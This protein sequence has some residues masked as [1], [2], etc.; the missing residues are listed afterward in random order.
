M[1]DWWVLS[2]EM[3]TFACVL[4]DG[5]FGHNGWLMGFFLRNGDLCLCFDW[6]RLLPVFWWMT[7]CQNGWLMGFIPRNGN[8]CQ[9]SN[10]WASSPTNVYFTIRDFIMGCYLFSGLISGLLH[11]QWV[12]CPFSGL[13]S[14]TGPFSG[15]ISEFCPLPWLD[16]WA[17]T[18]FSG[19]TSEF[20]P[21]RGLTSEFCHF[22]GS[23]IG[24]YPISG[25]INELHLHQWFV[26]RAL[27]R[28]IFWLISSNVTPIKDCREFVL[29]CWTT[30]SLTCPI[31][32]QQSYLHTVIWVSCI[33]MHS[34]IHAYVARI[35][36]IHVCIFTLCLMSS[37]PHEKVVANVS[38]LKMLPN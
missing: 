14:E 33:F 21:F 38:D 29:R 32:S 34:F 30:F 15:L 25:L 7:F 31:L 13:I 24:I 19:L 8:L 37:I 28:S 2:R 17:F 18:P 12:I 5:D 3:A 26:W 11:I 27:S 6:W 22:S 36:F 23:I 20:R 10:G 16:Y 1:V 9:T 4:M 35:S